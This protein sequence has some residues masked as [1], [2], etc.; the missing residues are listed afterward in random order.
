MLN[1]GTDYVCDVITINQLHHE[2]FLLAFC[3]FVP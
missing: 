1:F 2:T 3:T